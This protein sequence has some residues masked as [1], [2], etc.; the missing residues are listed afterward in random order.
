MEDL[1]EPQ[2]LSDKSFEEIKHL[3][4]DHFKPKIS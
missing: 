3:L 4:L 2:K 1:C